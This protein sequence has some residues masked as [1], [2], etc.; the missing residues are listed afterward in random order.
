MNVL[1]VNKFFYLKG[2]SETVMFQ[3]R[4]FLI[5]QGIQVSDFSMADPRNIPSP[6]SEFFVS[7]IDYHH[8]DG[9]RN[10]I[11]KGI[12]FVH[13]FEA[14]EKLEKLIQKNRPDIAHLHNIYHQL[15]PSVIPV[16]KKYGVKVVL[17][18]H[19]GKLI[20]PGYLMLDKDKICTAC[21]GKYFWKP[22]TQNCQGSPTQGLLFM[23]EAFWHKWKGSYDQVDLFIAPSRF[24]G[25]LVSRRIPKDKIRVLH[26]GILLG[27]FVPNYQ[28]DGYGL[29]FG[30][31]SR[32]KGIETLLKAHQS[33]KDDLML[34]VVG[35]GPME[36]E[37]RAEYPDAEFMG[38]KKGDTLKKIIAKSAF[39][40]VPSEWY[41]NCSMVVLEAMAMGKPVIGAKIGGI[42]EQV[43]DGKTG[44]LFT[45]GKADEL[46]EKMKTLADHPRL[47]IEMGKAARKKLEADY[48]LDNHCEELLG[49]YEELES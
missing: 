10:K 44:F 12:S 45:M 17:T 24:I 27:E 20:C 2:G 38:Y 6:C 33:V 41:E 5:R 43:E 32:E 49:I 3:E 46:A 28:D 35:T 30:R 18:L 29:Y 37:L 36:D 40:I 22:L 4:D 13:S 42:P 25:E 7:H 16:L 9:I 21:D 11:Q 47:R 1:F 19:D 8:S 39:V 26:N 14:I 23:L 34:K 15:T 48:S 31:L